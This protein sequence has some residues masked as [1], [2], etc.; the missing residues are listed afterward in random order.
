M[1][2]VDVSIKW[3]FKWCLVGSSGSGKTEFSLQLV[4]NAFSLFDIPPSKII[5]VYKEFQDIYNKFNEYIPTTLY[6]EEDIDLEELTK[7]NQERLL[8]IC[9]DLYFSKK[10]NEV[11]EQFLIKGRHR[12]TSW[13]VLTQTIFNH[14]DLKNISRNS[15]HITLF[16][17]VRLTEP[18]IFFSQLRPQSSKV[19]QDIYREAT[20]EP[21]SYLDIDLSQTCPDKLRY[22]TDIFKDIIKV[23]I[24][25][26][27]ATF[28]TMYL[29][30]K[31]DLDRNVNKN[32]SLSLQNRDICQG[33]LNVSVRPIKSKLKG[34]NM[35]QKNMINV[36][37]QASQ[38]GSKKDVDEGEDGD[39]KGGDDDDDDDGGNNGSVRGFLEKDRHMDTLSKDRS[40]ENR[41][42]Q[43][44]LDISP[45]SGYKNNWETR[46]PRKLYRNHL[47]KSSTS[48]VRLV[49][50]FKKRSTT[51]KIKSNNKS[52]FAEKSTFSPSRSLT[53]VPAD[54]PAEQ[55]SVDY[56]HTDEIDSNL[57]S[58]AYDSD[59]N[60]EQTDSMT[61]NGDGWEKSSPRKLYK[62][63]LLRSKSGDRIAQKFRIRGK[64]S[65]YIKNKSIINDKSQ[66]IPS[67]ALT[68]VP[69]E[70]P[71]EQAY[72]QKD[73]TKANE[74]EQIENTSHN[75]HELT[76]LTDVK[77]ESPDGNNQR[78][79]QNDEWFGGL[80]SRLKD[81][82]VQF[83][84]K[85]DQVGYRINPTDISKS[86]IKPSDFRY[87][88]PVH[89]SE[90]I[91]KWKPLGKVKEKTFHKKRF[92]SY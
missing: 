44:N 74:G 76:D 57:K 56:E 72:E 33:G 21:Y 62:K 70:T 91:D 35:N 3:P 27:N 4:S 19:L 54:K 90:Y 61:E 6:K 5:I 81:R 39:D 29:V 64:T 68:Y 23:F 66:L 36:D 55:T 24:V 41:I 48:R 58:G 13:V 9:D 86:L 38:G 42:T 69:D 52:I 60:N 50:K 87:L 28:K 83:K 79:S 2:K 85:Q 75:S 14:P 65:K 89:S 8:I 59:V 7:F 80:R 73:L 26:N 51:S 77:E 15:T 37:T 92:K 12:N 18:H 34:N 20:E 78:N 71:V 53:Y 30:N 32:F 25:M 40:M 17:S 10:L 22:K 67:K 11:A 63:H 31:H 49:P 88:N 82:R 43:N 1:E 45:D 46:S 16:K 47:I 84:R